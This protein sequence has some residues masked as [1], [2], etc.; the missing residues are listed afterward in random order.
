MRQ[1]KWTWAEEQL[2][3]LLKLRWHQQPEPMPEELKQSCS[4]L[5]DVIGMGNLTP[6]SHRF[7]Q[8]YRT[9]LQKQREETPWSYS[10]NT[11]R[12]TTSDT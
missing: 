5:I 3:E 8:Y 10:I 11:T 9:A 7:C 6:T 1:R 4:D 12:V 2:F